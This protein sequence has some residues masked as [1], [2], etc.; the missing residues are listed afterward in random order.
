MSHATVPPSAEPTTELPEGVADLT[1]RLRARGIEPA[2]QTVVQTTPV[3]VPDLSV[4]T[5]QMPVVEH[6]PSRGAAFVGGSLR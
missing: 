5:V 2:A 3:G 4:G 1:A 6:R